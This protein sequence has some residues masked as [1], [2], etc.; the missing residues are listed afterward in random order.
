MYLTR[1]TGLRDS[2]AKPCGEIP[3]F[4]LLNRSGLVNLRHA[5][6]AIGGHPPEVE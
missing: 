4:F 6:Y 3:V 2:A 1:F 5:L